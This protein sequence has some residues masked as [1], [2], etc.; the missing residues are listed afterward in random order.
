MRACVVNLGCKVNRVESDGF[1]ALLAAAGYDLGSPQESDL[2]IVNT[3]TVTGEAEK[4][5]RKAVRKALRQ[6]A[7]APVLVTGCAA[8][9]DPDEFADMDGRV[10]VVPKHQMVNAIQAYVDFDLA[11]LMAPLLRC[12]SNG[13]LLRQHPVRCAFAFRASSRRMS[14]MIS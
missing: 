13:C 7:D 9:I 12:C 10:V 3:C 2:I 5:T 4:K 11:H 14:A 1:E 8:V 6:S